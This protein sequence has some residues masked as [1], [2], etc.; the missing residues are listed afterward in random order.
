MHWLRCIR[1][2]LI[3]E[4]RRGERAVDFDA[5]AAAGAVGFS[6]DGETTRHSGIM[7]EALE[8]S[9]TLGLPVMVHCEDPGLIGGAMHEGETSRRLGLRAIPGRR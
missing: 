9:R 4:G 1:L 6:D 5:L 3:S 2:P 8:A 7:R